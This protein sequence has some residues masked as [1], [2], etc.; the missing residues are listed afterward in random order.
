VDLSSILSM[1]TDDFFAAMIRMAAPIIF[2]ATGEVILQRSGIIN[3]GMESMFM[4]GAFFGVVGADILKNSWGGL[5]TAMLAG[6]LTGLLYG[7]I[8]IT[9][10]G[11]QSVTGTAFNILGFGLTSFFSRVF[12]GIRD[13]PL[14]VP[15]IKVLPIPGLS[16]IPWVGTIFFNQNILVYVAYLMVPLATFF[17]FRTIWGLKLR[18][19]GEHPRAADTLGINIFRWRYGAAVMAGTL[20]AIGGAML[21]LAEIGMFSDRMSGGRGYFAL[22]AVIF[23]GWKPVGAM[24]AC[25]LFG[26][27]TALQMRLQ[28]FGVPISS[29]LLII[30]PFVLTLIV[31]IAS[32]STAKPKALAKAYEKEPTI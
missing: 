30:I 11:N 16:D 2:A 7:F 19:I 15:K 32:K 23:G 21:S 27:G 26:A 29:D 3:L 13:N 28:V 18:S 20:A 6:A 4:M 5:L 17:L 8:V 10:R 12:W 25:L 9:L 24:F 31:V 14:Q 22:A 1:F